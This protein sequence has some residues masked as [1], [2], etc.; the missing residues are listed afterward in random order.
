MLLIM[1]HNFVIN[2]MG[3]RCNE[4]VY[5]EEYTDVFLTNVFGK[6]FV[7]C[8]FSYVGWVGVPIFLFL[9]GYGLTLKFNTDKLVVGSYIKSHVVKLL[10]L[11]APIFVLYF[12]VYH[13][14]LGEVHNIKSAVAQLTFLINFL[15]Y[16]NN[17]FIIEP[18]VY[19]FF[20]A[21]LQFYLLFIVLRR[22]QTKWLWV[23]ACLFLAV[24]Y[25]V[26]YSCTNDTMMWTR[27]NFLG[28]GA[29]FVLGMIS[30]RR[31]KTLP[32]RYAW[33]IGLCSLIAL[34]VFMVFKPLMPLVEL[35]AILLFV[36]VV[37]V[38]TIR[39]MAF[40]GII[41]SSIFVL[42]PVVRM[43][44]RVVFYDMFTPPKQ[45]ILVLTLIYFVIVVSLSW[46]HHRLMSKYSR[47]N[48]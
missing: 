20:G 29:P 1:I 37:S 46:L 42:H 31:Q 10:K 13:F 26:L 7:W 38:G 19:W 25:F 15:S 34:C 2:F 44:V 43:F 6:D 8:V 41:S 39:P 36:C 21:I 11:L 40:I 48:G 32:R 28:W 33:S 18:G 4:M 23:L 24:N 17:G 35:S 30:A 22:L 3:I 14:W 12:V 45:Y 16:G 27:H 5:S 9:S 47:N